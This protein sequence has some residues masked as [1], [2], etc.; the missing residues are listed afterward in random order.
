M[1][2]NDYYRLVGNIAIG[3]IDDTSAVEP[4]MKDISL[5]LG[6]ACPYEIRDNEFGGKDLFVKFNDEREETRVTSS[7]ILI[8]HLYRGRGGV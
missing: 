6:H 1:E 3:N 2:K 8:D 5:L 7:A 4:I